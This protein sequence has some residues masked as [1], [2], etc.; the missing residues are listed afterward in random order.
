M[1]IAGTKARVETYITSFKNKDVVE[2]VRKYDE[3]SQGAV[4]DFIMWAGGKYN[5]NDVFGLVTERVDREG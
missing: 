3:E 1:E 5:L 4:F 2:Q